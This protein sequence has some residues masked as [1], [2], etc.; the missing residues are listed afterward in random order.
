MKTYKLDHKES[1]IIIELVH[2]HLDN[3]GYIKDRENECDKISGIL[4]YYY[5]VV[6]NVSYMPKEVE[7]EIKIKS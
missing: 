7:I 4:D 3:R 6:D 5:N 2:E 1:E